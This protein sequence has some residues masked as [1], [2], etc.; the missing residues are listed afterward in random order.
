MHRISGCASICIKNSASL[1]M[2]IYKGKITGFSAHNRLAGRVKTKQFPL[3]W[4]DWSLAR[5]DRECPQRSK[6][7][8]QTKLNIR[9]D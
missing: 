4:S 9:P 8:P 2:G 7:I 1:F 6:E 3:Q 5:H